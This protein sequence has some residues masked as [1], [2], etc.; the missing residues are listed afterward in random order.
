MSSAPHLLL[1][2]SGHGYGH[3]AQCAPVI[4]ALW[5][6][7][8]AL[9][10]TVC[11]SLAR[12]VIA[13]RLD[14]GFE[15]RQV[16]L[17]PVLPMLSAWEVDVAASGRLYREFHRD[18]DSGLQHDSDLLQQLGPDL[19]LADIPYRILLAAQRTAIPA[20]ALC[21]LN[22]ASIHAA[23]C[24]H[25]AGSGRIQEQMRAGYEAAEVF[26]APQPAL[27]MPELDNCRS[28][29]PIARPG[30]SRKAELLAASG[31]P[32][33]TRIVMIALGGVATRLPLANWPRSKDIVWMLAGAAAVD[34]DD[35]ID[36]GQAGL[37]FIDALASA[38]AVITKPGYGTYAEAVCNGVPLLS[39]ERPD[40]PET[41]HLNAWARRHGRLLE[42]APQQFTGGELAAILERLW[43]L[44]QKPPPEPAGIRQASEVM[45]RYL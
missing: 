38:D 2:L 14:R 3:L 32:E 19:V 10:L 34:R 25:E 5:Q 45:T 20:I 4:N 9:Q 21:S 23:Y 6:D 28:I 35:L 15:Y 39:L 13:A 16:E 22:W 37:S 33:Q 17:D 26:L 40:W 11:G 31:L 43:Q 44:P 1:A 7:V 36:P 41:R 8:P 18:L 24:G 12:E 30:T 27:P 29:G 42:I